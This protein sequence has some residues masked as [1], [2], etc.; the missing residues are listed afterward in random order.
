[1]KKIL[2]IFTL[3]GSL[4]VVHAQ[5]SFEANL[6]GLQ[7]VPPNISPAFGLGDFSLS[8][9]TLSVTT[10][11]YQDL[12][13]TSTAVTLHDAA[14][15][16]NG[17]VIFLLTLDSPG[18]T[19]GTFSGSGALTVGQIADLD[20]GNL[21]VSIHSTVVPGGEIRGQLEPVPEPATMALLGAGSL[22]LLAMRRRKV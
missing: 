12:L 22:A 3:L 13:G 15:G 11:T 4:T 9:T 16:V 6:D 10:G 14:P 20:S 1:M 21:Y 7:V 8:G 19:I 18:T 5:S 2:I 17:P